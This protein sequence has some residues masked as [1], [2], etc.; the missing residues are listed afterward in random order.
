MSEIATLYVT[1]LSKICANSN[2]AESVLSP[3]NH[4]IKRSPICVSKINNKF[5]NITK[6]LGTYIQHIV[7]GKSKRRKCKAFFMEVA[8]HLCEN[9]I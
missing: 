4:R 8:M 9:K 7:K 5:V 6:Y 2:A 3:I 1:V